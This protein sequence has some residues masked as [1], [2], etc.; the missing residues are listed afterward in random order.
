MRPCRQSGKHEP[1]LV[2]IAEDNDGKANLIGRRLR[3]QGYRA[4][5]GCNGRDAMEQMAHLKPDLVT[6][7]LMMPDMN[8]FQV[9]DQLKRGGRARTI[10]G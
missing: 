6:P 7:D 10:A 4:A 8:G 5:R 2:L 9:I 3:N 1:P